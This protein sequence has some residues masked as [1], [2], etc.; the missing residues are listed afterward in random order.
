[1]EKTV[2]WDRGRIRDFRPA[3]NVLG[4][5]VFTQGMGP[6]DPSGDIHA[7]A[8]RTLDRLRVVL[9]D[10]GASLRGVVAITI[11]LSDMANYEA[12]NEDY[13]RYFS[14]DPPARTCI[15]GKGPSAGSGQLIEI[16]AIASI[17]AS[18]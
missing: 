4:D 18:R 3:A 12:M 10:A 9:E 15:E 16:N 2:L 14:S 5:L 11:Y 13:A 8:I 7:Q 1:M 6:G 17:S